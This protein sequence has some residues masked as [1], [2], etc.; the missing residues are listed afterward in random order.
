MTD[1]IQLKNIIRR[2]SKESLGRPKEVGKERL[3][4]L[5]GYRRKIWMTN[6]RTNYLRMSGRIIRKI[7]NGEV[8]SDKE[9]RDTIEY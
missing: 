7:V 5:G 4:K 3:M 1:G 9:L 8:V 6:S 2:Y